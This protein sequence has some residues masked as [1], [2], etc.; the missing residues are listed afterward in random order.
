MKHRKNPIV[1][2]ALRGGSRRND[3]KLLR[4]AYRDGDLP[5]IRVKNRG[6]RFVVRKKP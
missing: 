3:T 2:H 5:E 4:V 1:F 6:F